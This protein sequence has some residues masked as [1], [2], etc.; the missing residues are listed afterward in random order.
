MDFPSN[1]QQHLSTIFYYREILK[2]DCLEST[3]ELFR[4]FIAYHIVNYR[5]G[6][7]AIPKCDYWYDPNC[8]DFYEI[9][10]RSFR[11]WNKYGGKRQINWSREKIIRELQHITVESIQRY[12]K[13][14]YPCR[15]LKEI[16]EIN[17]KILTIWSKDDIPNLIKLQK[18]KAKRYCGCI[19]DNFQ[20]PNNLI[21]SVSFSDKTAKCIEDLVNNGNIAS[22]NN[23]DNM[24]EYCKIIDVLKISF[25]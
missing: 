17:P 14:K 7:H 2:L 9:E 16:E 25:Q 10:E 12:L 6:I 4:F 23:A 19:L 21:L 15:Q 18:R 24:E 1:F 22:H 5:S 20:G 3:S 13:D 8:D 11:W